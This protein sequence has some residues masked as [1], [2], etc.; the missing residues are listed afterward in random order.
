MATTEILRA[1]RYALD[2]TPGQVEILQR[3]TVAA[4]CGFNFALGYMTAVHQ[5]WQRGRDALVAEGLDKA[6]ANKQAPKVRI[7]NAARAQAFFR[8]TKGRPFTGPLRE[9]E[10][11]R[12]PYPWWEAVN[13]RAYYTAMDDAATAFKNW[14]DSVSGR[15]AGPRVGYPDFKRRGCTRERFR[16]VHDTKNPSIRFD[17][18]RRLRIPGGDGQA[19][20]TIRLHQSARDLVRLINDGQATITSVTVSRDGHR[21][22]ASVLCRVHQHI[23]TGPSRRQAAA[24]RIGADLGVKSLAAFSDPLTLAAGP[25][26]TIPNPRHLANTRSKLA[27]AQRVMSRRFVK[28]ARPQSKGYEEA[29]ARVAK[30]HAQLAARRTS[31]LHLISKRLVQQYAEVA[32]ETLN[33]KG[34]TASAR[35]TVEKPGRNVRQKAGLNR[36]ILDVSFGE[37]SRQIEYKAVWHGV[38]VVRVPTFFP[39]SKTC[40]A[41]GWV[42][43]YQTLKD[44]EFQCRNCGLLLDRDVNAA[45]NIKQ[46]ATVIPYSPK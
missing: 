27:R 36:S 23:P 11:P 32:L 10:E 29:R 2:A 13:N 18:S 28:G 26:D 37:L 38:T 17:G 46:H 14:M 41:C 4:R 12:T 33:V 16:I 1:Y 6:V 5:I 44:R 25:V 3:Y 30:L 39:S 24:G 45:R 43:R 34:M 40:S 15:R 19:A 7:P 21:W 31:A 22:F 8:Q 35:G 42:D 20:F 9:G